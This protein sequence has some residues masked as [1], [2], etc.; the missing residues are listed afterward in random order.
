MPVKASQISFNEAILRVATVHEREV[1]FRYEKGEK[2]PIETR[3]FTPEGIKEGAKGNL[4]PS[5]AMSFIGH[6]PDRGA[7]RTFRVDRI[8]G[9]VRIV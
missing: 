4:S 7:L 1:E 3:R 8:K 9:D 2:Q 6:D 5:A